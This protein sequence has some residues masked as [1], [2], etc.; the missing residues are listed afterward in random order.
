MLALWLAALDADFEITDAPELAERLRTFAQR[1][2]RA[3]R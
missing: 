2:L 3:V 1:Y